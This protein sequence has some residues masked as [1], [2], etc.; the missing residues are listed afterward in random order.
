M[1]SH[2]LI[3]ANVFISFWYYEWQIGAKM[4]ICG[5]FVRKSIDMSQICFNNME[6][7]S[8][9][10]IFWPGSSWWIHRLFG[11]KWNSQQALWK[12]FGYITKGTS[13]DIFRISS[14]CDGKRDCSQTLL[15]S[16]LILQL[17]M[18]HVNK[19]DYSVARRCALI[20]Q[21]PLQ[22]S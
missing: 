10:D 12:Q 13:I 6:S 4:L 17:W 7:I 19:K 20:K 3:L 8:S 22:P 2:K 5:I 15:A 11:P 1:P 21:T 18:F 16:G 14:F 9:W